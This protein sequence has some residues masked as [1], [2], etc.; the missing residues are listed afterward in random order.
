MAIYLIAQ[1][2]VNDHIDLFYKVD[3][4]VGDRIWSIWIYDC[5]V[6]KH[7]THVLMLHI[8]CA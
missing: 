4:E 3:E 1:I 7:Q 5:I 6:F 8:D 2:F